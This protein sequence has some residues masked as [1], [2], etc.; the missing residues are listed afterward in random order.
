MNIYLNL[1]KKITDIE[2]FL[3]HSNSWKQLTV[4]KRYLISLKMSSIKCVY[5]SYVLN[6]YVQ[7]GFA[8]K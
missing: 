3:L 5:K 4:Q 6:I 2:L 7:T 1:Y 8:I